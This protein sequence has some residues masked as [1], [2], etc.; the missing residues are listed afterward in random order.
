[1]SEYWAE[2]VRTLHGLHTRGFPNC[3]IMGPQQSGFT[4]NFP[5][6]LDEQARHIAYVIG[7]TIERGA[8]TVETTAEAEE[9]WV[10]R[11]ISSAVMSLNFLKE[12][13]PG[14][15]NNEGQV[16]QRA[17]QN[18]WFGGGS[19]EFFR[20]LDTWRRDGKLAGLELDGAPAA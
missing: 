12:C 15:Y 6:M 3:F 10:Q 16:S 17:A 1:L 5:H 20:M 11:V 9:A 18:G 13:T 8:T 19:I 14:Y 2:G 4:V 7:E